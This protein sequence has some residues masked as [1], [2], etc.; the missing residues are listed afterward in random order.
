V[1]RP[2]AFLVLAHDD[3]PHLARLCRRLAPHPVYVHLDA[4]AGPFE[5]L[6]LDL[7]AN[8]MVIG[9]RHEVHWADFSVVEA[10]LAL[11]EAARADGPAGHT[12]LLSGHCYPARP[13][14]EL[15]A[16]L[17][18]APDA[19]HIA[20]A[21]VGPASELRNN[22]G[23]RWRMA[24]YLPSRWRRR[25]PLLARADDLARRVRN[26]LARARRRDFA[27]EIAPATHYHGSQWWALT[28]ESIHAIRREAA[29]PRWASF[30]TT[31]APD[32]TFFHTLVGAAAGRRQ[33]ADPD[34]GTRNLYRAPLHFV[35]ETEGR[36]LRDGPALRQAIA[37]SSRFFVR[38]LG[39]AHAGLCDWLD[40]RVGDEADAGPARRRGL[41]RC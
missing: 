16:F 40:G 15:Q 38:K 25:F 4:K 1:N 7:P 24:P 6:G 34:L 39:S 28:E 9:R 29:K 20:M 8:A 22:V 35:A 33:V 5:R 18:G 36:W 26:R 13:V 32:E 3:P 19:D 27:A 31:W 2:L 41:G 12:V 10:T 21:A 11:I 17:A 30:R 14:A 23:R 37:G